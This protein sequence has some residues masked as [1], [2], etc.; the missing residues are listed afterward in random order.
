MTFSTILLLFEVTLLARPI[1]E[2]DIVLK[3]I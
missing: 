1:V 2:I 3:G